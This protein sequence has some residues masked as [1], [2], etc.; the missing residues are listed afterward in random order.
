[1]AVKLLCFDAPL[2]K[3]FTLSFE[4]LSFLNVDFYFPLSGQFN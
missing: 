1:M 2:L 3:S 4:Y